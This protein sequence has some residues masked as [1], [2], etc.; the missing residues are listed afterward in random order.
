MALLQ[1]LAVDVLGEISGAL[2]RVAPGRVSIQK[3]ADQSTR[4]SCG[5]FYNC[6]YNHIKALKGLISGL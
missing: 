1:S 5:L 3:E 4:N 6:T 2:H